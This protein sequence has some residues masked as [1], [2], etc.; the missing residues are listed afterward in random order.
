MRR[1]TENFIKSVIKCAFAGAL[2]FLCLHPE[3]LKRLVYPHIYAQPYNKEVN[4]W[5][6]DIFADAVAERAAPIVRDYNSTYITFLPKE[7]YA[8]VARIGILERYDG[9]WEKFYHGYDKSR[10]IY[11]TFAPIDLALVHGKNAYHEKFDTC[12]RHEYRLL[13]SCPEISSNYFN[14]YHMIPATDSLRKGLETLKKG[15]IVYIKGRLVNVKLPNGY[16]M[17]TGLSHNMTHKDQ[18]AGGQYSGMCFILFLEKMAVDG[19]IY[20]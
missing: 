8:V 18:F 15:D 19:F 12:F 5:E 6:R 14:N 1:Q 11:N 9:W 7:E 17:N 4:V 3:H 10:Q 2:L 20:E 13:W 16:E